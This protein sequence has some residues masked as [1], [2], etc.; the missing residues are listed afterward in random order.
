[1]NCQKMKKRMMVSSASCILTSMGVSSILRMTP[2]NHIQTFRPTRLSDTR[3]F[4][5]LSQT[6]RQSVA[7]SKLKDA[8]VTCI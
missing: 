1:M 6:C 7:A 5:R 4:F 2:Q 8:A 3:L